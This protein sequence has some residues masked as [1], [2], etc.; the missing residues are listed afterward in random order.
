M[1]SLYV[2]LLALAGVLGWLGYGH[3]QQARREQAKV[4]RQSPAAKAV[5]TPPVPDPARPAVPSEYFD[6]AGRTLFSKDRNPAVVIEPPPVKPEPPMP[7]L[8]RY[9]GQMAIGDPVAIFSLA[10][11]PQKAYRVGESIGDFKI[12]S[13][14]RERIAFQWND[15]TVERRLEELIAKVEPQAVAGN[16]VPPPPS[17]PAAASPRTQPPAASSSATSLSAGTTSLGAETTATA[18]TNPAIGAEINDGV[19]NCTPGDKS[20]AGTIMDGYKKV[21]YSTMFGSVCQWEPTK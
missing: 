5:L 1:I 7:P 13:F 4:L 21:I 17:Q 11:G 19:R 18:P 9:H 10:N 3:W 8:P 15:K 14:D 12:T 20:A 2:L 16:S 6:V